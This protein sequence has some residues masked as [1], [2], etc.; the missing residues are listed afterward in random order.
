MATVP[1]IE[2]AQHHVSKGV[3]RLSED[4]IEKG[5]GSWL[6]FR[7]GRTALDFTCGIGVT[8]LGTSSSLSAFLLRG[9]VLSVDATI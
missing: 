2:F 5:E 6:T 9:S 1:S 8:N 4:I 7:S 3:V